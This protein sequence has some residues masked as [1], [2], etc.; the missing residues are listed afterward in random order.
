MGVTYDAML[1][2]FMA[3]ME[4]MEAKTGASW[5]YDIT[6]TSGVYKRAFNQVVIGAKELKKS[7]NDGEISNTNYVSIHKQCFHEYRH[8]Q[9]YNRFFQGKDI[10]DVP[11]DVVRHMA[12]QSMISNAFPNYV[13]SS[14]ARDNYFNMIMEIDAEEYALVNSR[15]YLSG[16]GI[17]TDEELEY[18]LCDEINRRDGWWGDTP[19][20]SVDDA[21]DD[22]H[23]KKLACKHLKLKD[24]LVPENVL[25]GLFYRM[26]INNPEN[27][28]MYLSLSDDEQDQFLIDYICKHDV[29][30]S[31]R[32]PIIAD[33]FPDLSAK[34]KVNRFAFR[35]TH[36]LS[37]NN[38]YDTQKTVRRL[39]DIKMDSDI[40]N[41]D[42]FE[43]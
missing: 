40:Q 36:G 28:R 43:Y 3:L 41:A 2:S 27:M 5:V 33:R 4:E 14:I 34:E 19:V 1:D 9:Q 11:V 10:N 29:E 17:L 30:I 16:K 13:H 6:T 39:P 12:V 37:D 42:D 8:W 35:K 20:Y 22:L 23:I 21:I 31:S 7:R 38:V 18:S 26:F 25:R 24:A 15:E 32:Y